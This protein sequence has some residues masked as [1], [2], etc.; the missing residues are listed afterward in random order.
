ML[1]LAV[2]GQEHSLKDTAEFLADKF[3]LTADERA[4]L[5]PSGTT[6]YLRNRTG[7]ARTYL[8][9][10]GL[11]EIPREGFFKITEAGRTYLKQAPDPI[12]PRD[13][14]VFEGFAEFAQ[15]QV[16]KH[17]APKPPV[18]EPDEL[19][20]DEVIEKAYTEYVETLADDIIDRTLKSSPEFFERLVVKLLVTMGYGGNVREAGTAVG[21]SGDEGIDGIIKE[22]ALGLD[23]IYVQAKR[24]QGGVGAPEIQKFV[25]ALAQK[26][27]S[28]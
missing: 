6:T 1:E 26:K 24:W 16:S 9:K 25:G 18:Q 19:T 12:K 27:A 3:K 28:K 11:L 15:A 13:L 2:D 5:L 4:Q 10:A 17:G 23:N 7:W 8:K 22:D 14:R 21:R 20:P